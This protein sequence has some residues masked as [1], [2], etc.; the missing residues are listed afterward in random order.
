MRHYAKIIE[1]NGGGLTLY[2]FDDNTTRCIYAHSGYEHTPGQL[3]QD[4]QALI[5]DDDVSDWEGYESEVAEGWE[6]LEIDTILGNTL[7]AEVA[8]GKLSTYPAK[9]GRAGQ[10]EFGVPLM[11]K[12]SPQNP[13]PGFS[14]GSGRP[15]AGA[16]VE[17]RGSYTTRVEPDD[18]FTIELTADGYAYDAIHFPSRQGGTRLGERGELSIEAA[19]MRAYE[20]WRQDWPSLTA[21]ITEG[22]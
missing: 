6:D 22:E 4:L 21:P 9:M 18:T 12:Y 15:P 11:S 16:R 3:S 5:D 8:D 19:Y 20:E 10:V 1:D 7:I 17:L 2:I 14:H 13:A